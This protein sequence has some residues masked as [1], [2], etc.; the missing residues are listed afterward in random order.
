MVQLIP[1]NIR[2]SWLACL[3]LTALLGGCSSS[4]V[5]PGPQPAAPPDTGQAPAATPSP[6]PPQTPVAPKPDTNTATLAL[7][8]QSQQAQSAGSLNEAIAYTER[9][10]RISPRQAD[11]WIRLASLELANGQPGNAIQYANKALTLA[12]ERTDWQRQSWLIIADAKDAQGNHAE[13]V[14]IRERWQTYRG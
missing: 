13:A 12:G 9:A 14:T 6:A 5:A 7:L 10:I 11:L 2:S 3:L 4:A 8:Q 1:L